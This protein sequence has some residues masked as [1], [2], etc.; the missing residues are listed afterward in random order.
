MNKKKIKKNKG[1]L[2]L[3]VSFIAVPNYEYLILFRKKNKKK[4]ETQKIIVASEEYFRWKSFSRCL[5]KTSY[6]VS[7][8]SRLH[9]HPGCGP[10]ARFTRFRPERKY[11]KIFAAFRGKLHTAEKPRKLL[12]VFFRLE[13]GGGSRGWQPG[14]TAYIS[15]MRF[16]TVKQLK[17]IL[18]TLYF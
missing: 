12:L 8:S 7:H 1:R 2:G 11:A 15:K 14:A 17:N 13:N 10:V 18:T 4:Q 9:P 3:L 16:F 5:E 6:L